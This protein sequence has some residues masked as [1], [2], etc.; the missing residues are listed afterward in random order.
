MREITRFSQSKLS[1]EGGAEEEEKEEEEDACWEERYFARSSAQVR[2]LERS[3]ASMRVMGLKLE[4][5]EGLKDREA[6]RSHARP[7]PTTPPPTM[8]MSESMW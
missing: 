4:V 6:M 2:R 7:R 1:V 5:E 3:D 8:T